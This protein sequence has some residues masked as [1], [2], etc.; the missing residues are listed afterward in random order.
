MNDLHEFR[1]LM[2][3]VRDRVIRIETNMERM[4]ALE[5]KVERHGE[6][7]LKAKTSVKVLRWMFWAAIIALP[8]SAAAILKVLNG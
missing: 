6:E 8:A 7:I 2:T 3:D 4:P 1:E 5:I